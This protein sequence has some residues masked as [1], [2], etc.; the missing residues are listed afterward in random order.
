RKISSTSGGFSGALTSDSF[1]WS[2]TAMGDLNGDDVVELAVGATGDDDGGTN[3]G[4]VWVL[5][6]DDSPCVPDLNGDCVVDLADINAFTTGF[7]TQDPIAD[8]AYPVGVFDLAD[9]NTF[10]ATFVAGCS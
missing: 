3:R 4:A 2:V 8:L 1:G 10:V 7:L 9:I 5:F 6:L